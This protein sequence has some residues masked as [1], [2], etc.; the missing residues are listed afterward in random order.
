VRFVDGATV[1]R[2]EQTGRESGGHVAE[3][4]PLGMI[5]PYDDD[6]LLIAEHVTQLE[7]P[8]YAEIDPRRR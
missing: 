8:E 2:R 4:F 3:S 6:A 5:W 1:A 7:A